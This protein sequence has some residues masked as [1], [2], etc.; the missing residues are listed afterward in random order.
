MFAPSSLRWIPRLSPRSM[1]QGAGEIKAR[2]RSRQVEAR[3]GPGNAARRNARFFRFSTWLRRR[4]ESGREKTGKTSLWFSRLA[5]SAPCSETFCTCAYLATAPRLPLK[6][7]GAAVDTRKT[8]ADD[9]MD[10]RKRSGGGLLLPF[11]F[12]NQRTNP[13]LCLCATKGARSFLFRKGRDGPCACACESLCGMRVREEGGTG[14]R[15]GREVKEWIR[16]E[17]FFVFGSLGLSVRVP[18]DLDLDLDLLDLDLDLDLDLFFFLS[19]FCSPS[20]PDPE[21]P[22]TANGSG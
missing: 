21:S 7:A 12:G 9:M 8:R 5:F 2:A 10:C 20:P 11:C 6:A 16:R 4:G 3:P 1:H 22:L 17:Q 18:L 15:R 19:V 14:E 13:L